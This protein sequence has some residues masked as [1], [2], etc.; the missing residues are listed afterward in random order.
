MSYKI[1]FLTKFQPFLNISIKTVPYL[2]H[3]LACHHWSNKIDNVLRRSGQKTTQ[4]QIKMIVSAGRKVFENL[5]LENYISDINKN[6][7]YVYH[8]H[9]CHW[10][11]PE[12]NKQV[13]ERGRWRVEGGFSKG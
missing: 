4:K 12:K 2:M 3:H 1:S 5:K 11:F 6:T 8:L 7:K 10:I 9:T 13:G